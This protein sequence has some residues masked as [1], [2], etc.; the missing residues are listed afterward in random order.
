MKYYRM[1]LILGILSA[2]LVVSSFF[3][4]SYTRNALAKNQSKLQTILT[5][6][7]QRKDYVK[8]MESIKSHSQKLIA[9]TREGTTEINYEIVL[10]DH[11]VKNLLSKVASTYSDK[12]FFLDRGSIESK[13]TGLTVT[14]KGFKMGG[15]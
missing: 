10:T 4:F 7:A 11:D 14:L 13:P 9:L 2:F 12:I 8:K 15:Q 3:Y 5:T 1:A 6:N